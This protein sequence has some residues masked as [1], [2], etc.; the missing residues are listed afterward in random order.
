MTYLD[1]HALLWLYENPA[2]LPARAHALLDSEE[3]WLSP[4]VALE[5]Q[6]LHETGRITVEPGLV[7]ENG[8]TNLGLSLDGP[9]AG[10]A[11]VWARNFS[12]TRDPFDR[13]I[14]A[15]ASLNG[16][17]LI[18]KDATMRRNYEWAVWD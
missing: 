12:W 18:T 7:L 15:Q 4:M 3:L 1:T 16:A 2:L 17:L 11:I 10:P 13:I 8:Y 6:Y 9:G 14:T 5:L